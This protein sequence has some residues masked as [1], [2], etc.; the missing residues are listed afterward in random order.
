MPSKVS[1]PVPT[2]DDIVSCERTVLKFFSWDL[3]FILPLHVLRLY[4]A[5][6]IFYSNEVKTAVKNV[7]PEVQ[8]RSNAADPRKV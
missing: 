5:N 1:F 7:S 6:G 8:R 4:L 2:F 3:K